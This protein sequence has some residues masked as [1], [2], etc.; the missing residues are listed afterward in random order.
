MDNIEIKHKITTSND[1]TKIAEF[2]KNEKV[3]LLPA[4]TIYGL[5]CRY[6]SKNALNKIYDIKGRDKLVPF[7]ILIS[8]IQDLFNFTN[9]ISDNCKKLINYY[10]D[11][12]EPD[13]L[14]IIF[15]KNPKISDYITSGKDTIAIRRAEFEFVRNV[16]DISY[17][18]VSTSAT[19]SGINNNPVELQDID[20]KILQKVDLIVEFK[21][22]LKGIQ[23]TIIDATENEI[24][25]VREGAISFNDILQKL[26]IKI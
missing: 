3:I 22:K 17:P 23:S 12:K 20:F 9:E 8:K 19:I 16:I 14:T 25:L 26:Q 7:I 18:I 2:I 24:K 15:K 4:K 21:E 13:S 11:K 1:V 10:W 5:S 6:D